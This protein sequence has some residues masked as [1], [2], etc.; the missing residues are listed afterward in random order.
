MLD[1]SGSGWGWGQTSIPKISSGGWGGGGANVHLQNK[2]RGQTSILEISS[3][4]EGEGKCPGHIFNWGANVHLYIFSL[5][6][7]CPGGQMSGDRFGVFIVCICQVGPFLDLYY[8]CLCCYY[9]YYYYNYY[10]YYVHL[11]Y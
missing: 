8:Y 6:G 5:G 4:G 9:Y 3:W 11:Q 1:V 2:H 10:R 7:K